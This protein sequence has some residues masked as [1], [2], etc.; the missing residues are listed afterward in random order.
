MGS[1]SSLNGWKADISFRVGVRQWFSDTRFQQL[2][3]FFAERRTATDEITFFTSE[4]HSPLPLDEVR[5]RSE[6]LKKRMRQVRELGFS[7]GIN[8][9]STTGHHTENIENSFSG[10]YTN[11]TDIQG[12]TCP[13]VFCMADQNYRRDYV[14]PVYTWLT[15]AEPDYIWVDD[16]VRLAWHAPV[17]F[18]CFCQ[19]CLNRFASETGT[20]YTREEL[21]KVFENPEKKA[22]L[23]IRKQ[24]LEHNRQSTAEFLSFIENVVHSINPDMPLGFM[25][26]SRFYEGYPM[27]HWAEALAGK[28]K[29]TVRWR[30]GGGNYE[31]IRL[32]AAVEKAHQ[33]G[34]EA[35]LLPDWVTSI[36]SELESFSYERLAK[37][38][39]YTSLESAMYIA[40]GCTGTAYNVLSQYDEPLN[41][42]ASLVDRLAEIRPFLD[43]LASTFGRVRPTGIYTGWNQDSFVAKDLG[44]T[45]WLQNPSMIPGVGHAEELFHIGLPPAYR[46]E[47]SSVTVLNGDSVFVLDDQTIRQILS[48]GVYMDAEALRN[49]NEMG[50]GEL[51][52]FTVAEEHNADSLQQLLEHPIN[53]QFAGRFRDGRQSFW[54]TP[55]YALESN[56]D[57]AESIA[58]LIDYTYCTVAPCTT[59]VFENKLKGRVCVNGYFPWSK[60]QSLS[61]TSQMKSIFR[62]LSRDTLEAYISSYHRIN[63]WHRILADGSQATAL[64]NC[65][66]DPAENVILNLLSERTE[67]TFTDIDGN[68]TRITANQSAGPY[69]QYKL[70]TLDT[71]QIYLVAEI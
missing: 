49:L 62:W 55:A 8:I 37:S 18:S 34:M 10:A 7:S 40:A 28:N 36:Q 15:E 2:L 32:D 65:Y 47:D 69:K 16:D 45:G 52:G 46:F 59:G 23:Q 58:K 35:A 60:L 5:E 12:R 27:T 66:L 64:V 25:D 39:R 9:L 71:W 24:W 63:L 31:E 57:G 70:P 68:Q 21:Q 1:A 56:Q 11:A 17:L 61:M 43:R 4:T 22:A 41:E 19:N 14:E 20:N 29:A 53:G 13:G 42:Y 44:K 30:P 33:L 6:L 48:S 3:K 26:G 54:N 38:M 50:Y 67:I 51:T